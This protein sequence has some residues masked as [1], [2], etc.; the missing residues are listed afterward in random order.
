MSKKYRVTMR[1]SPMR[2]STT[3]KSTTRKSTM[4]KYSRVFR[5]NPIKRR[6]SK[7]IRKAKSKKKASTKK[8]YFG[9]RTKVVVVKREKERVGGRIGETEIE[10]E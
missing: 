5:R 10:R 9:G 6:N 1:K 3:R 8:H 2:K 7:T 4:R